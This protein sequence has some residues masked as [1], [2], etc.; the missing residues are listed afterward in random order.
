MTTT[1]PNWR[2][3]AARYVLFAA[4]REAGFGPDETFRNVRFVARSCS[5]S[6]PN[7]DVGKS[8]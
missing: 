5:T 3:G 2:N 6:G 8:T 4:L 1:L 7:A